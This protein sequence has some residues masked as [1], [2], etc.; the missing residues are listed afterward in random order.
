[1]WLLWYHRLIFALSE[2]VVDACC[3]RKMLYNHG[4]VLVEHREDL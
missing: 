3:A 4:D 2:L 1:M